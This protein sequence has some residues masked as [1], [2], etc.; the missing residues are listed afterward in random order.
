MQRART[1]VVVLSSAL[2]V[3][4]GAR[5]AGAQGP[6]VQEPL[7]QLEARCA[8]GDPGEAPPIR[9]VL[10][11]AR[12]VDTKEL[13]AGFDS[14]A[15][16]TTGTTAPGSPSAP[17]PS[18]KV[19]VEEDPVVVDP[20]WLDA[21]SGSEGN[22]RFVQAIRDIWVQGMLVLAVDEVGPALEQLE[23]Q[24][25]S[26]LSVQAD[27]PVDLTTIADAA[28]ITEDAEVPSIR[29][30]TATSTPL[31][32]EID[33]PERVEGS[34]LQV[35]KVYATLPDGRT[36]A[37][38]DGT[39]LPTLVAVGDRTANA[40]TPVAVEGAVI[41][42]DA[43]GQTVLIESTSQVQG[44]RG[45]VEK[46]ERQNADLKQ[47]LD[48]LTEEGDGGGTSFTPLLILAI[49]GLLG[50]I[51]YLVNRKPPAPAGAFADVP[52]GTMVPGALG[53][54]MA[55][56]AP[57]APVLSP[58]YTEPAPIEHGRA[59]DPAPGWTGTIPGG[60]SVRLED[61]GLMRVVAKQ[62][63]RGKTWS[64]ET[65][66][67]M[68]AGGWVEKI[69]GKGEDAEPAVRIHRSGSGLLAVFDGTGGAGAAS[70]R[71]LSDGSDLSGAYVASRLSKEVAEAWATEEIDRQGGA[72]QPEVLRDRLSRALQDEALY[73]DVPKS[74]MRGS[75][76]RVLPTT[77]AAV[78]FASGPDGVAA[79]ALWAGD[80]RA[81]VLTPGGGLQ[82]LTI[83]D[84][85]ETDALELIRN[86]QP[87]S[88]LVSADRPFTVNH[89]QYRFDQPAIL[90][91]ATDGCFGYVRTPAHFEFLLLD[92]LD[93]MTSL[94]TWAAELVDSLATIAADDSSFALGA[95]G[96]G[97][98]AD[99]QTAFQLRRS[100]L[101]EQHWVP[102]QRAADASEIEALRISSWEAYRGLYHARVLA[103]PEP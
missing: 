69:A 80:S 31:G 67:W 68:L 56:S 43:S 39:A 2:V 52:G 101:A 23:G 11:V 72:V 57:P 93:R 46:A 75:L 96:F 58:R 87:M 4:L 65:S 3:C 5:P 34:T 66:Q 50:A 89:L 8:D 94:D 73:P 36:A 16:S 100:Y 29:T 79:D 103:E 40:P 37:C 70:A 85:R 6:G 88:N 25:G 99:M 51:A 35:G 78:R 59:P 22:L 33:S 63:S 9:A 19:V 98:Y 76:Q 17:D 81:Y 95:F 86:D 60:S 27:E 41:A 84:T 42:T 83:D 91:T 92:S 13:L 49:L 77:M 55:P 97:S 38:P 7:S 1:L 71:R 14:A 18:P 102:F 48:D 82:V 74:T 12:G 53:G 61:L 26:N 28:E 47:R 21:P 44:L 24:R 54:S 62:A 32:L 30:V 45:Q 10:V 15:T 20:A 64:H 90:L